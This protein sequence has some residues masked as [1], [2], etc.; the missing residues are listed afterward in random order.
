MAKRRQGPPTGEIGFLLYEVMQGMRSHIYSAATDAQLTPQQIFMLHLL[1]ER[2]TSMSG[3]AQRLHCD[4]S[5]VT[6][7]ADRLESRGLV[8]RRDDP[9]D[10]RVKL[11]ALTVGGSDLIT[12]LNRR[13]WADS[14]IGEA[15]DETEQAQIRHLLLKIL[16]SAPVENR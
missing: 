6:G 11:L 9:E 10:R 2:P 14:P 4:A 8:E 16:S 3:L 5:N 15:L 7:L 1:L 12:D 13:I